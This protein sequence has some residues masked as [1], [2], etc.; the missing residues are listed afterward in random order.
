[1]NIYTI[2]QQQDYVSG[3]QKCDHNLIRNSIIIVSYEIL[4]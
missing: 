3:F 1:M 2:L 4:A